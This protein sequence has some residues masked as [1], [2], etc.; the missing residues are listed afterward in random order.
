MNSNALLCAIALYGVDRIVRKQCGMFRYPIE[1]AN[2]R[3]CVGFQCFILYYVMNNLYID[4][5]N[6][7]LWHHSLQ[8]KTIWA[9]D[10]MAGYFVYDLFILFSSARGRRQY[11]FVVHHLISLLIY[12]VNKVYPCGN[13]LLNNS[14]ILI[15]E[16]A[17]PCMNTWKMYEE[18]YPNAFL[19]N[20][21]FLTTR[22]LFGLSRMGFMTLW[23][24]YYLWTQYQFTWNHTLNIGGF[25]TVYVASIKWYMAMWR[26]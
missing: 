14:I 4:Y 23:L 17:N 18:L 10:Y 13:D 22:F 16:L 8:P 1:T 12:S 21:L 3:V 15:L 7:T 5:K 25:L 9:S 2:R 6:G 11:L 20:T 24:F 26:K 19:T